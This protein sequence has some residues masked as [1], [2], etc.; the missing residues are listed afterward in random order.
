MLEATCVICGKRSMD[1]SNAIG[2]CLECIRAAPHEIREVVAERHRKS[3]AAFHLPLQPP[4]SG[5]GLI[6]TLC[7][8]R[9]QMSHGQR[10]YC[11]LRTNLEGNLKQLAGTAQRGLLHWYR[12]PLPTNCVAMGVCAGQ[13]RKGHHN[14]AVFYGSCS[15]NCLYCQNWHYRDFAPT[16]GRVYPKPARD[17]SQSEG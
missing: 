10:G 5:E 3:R 7:S 12:D 11:G 2:V 9:C 1:I 6:C 4:R 16:A 15:F 17:H 8:N 14:L 13:G